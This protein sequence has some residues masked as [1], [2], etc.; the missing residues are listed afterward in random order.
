MLLAISAVWCHW[1][2]VMDQTTYSMPSVVD[3][4]NDRF[5]PI[6]VDSDRN[7]DINARYNMGGWPSTVFL[8]PNK[9][10]LTGATYVPPE[11]M[12]TLLQR[13]ADVYEAEKPDLLVRAKSNREAME[14]QFGLAHGSPTGWRDVDNVLRAVR[15]AYDPDYGGFG[16]EQKFPHTDALRLLLSNYEQRREEKDLVMVTFTLDAMIDGGVFDPVEGGMFR[17]ATQRNWSEPHYEKMLDDNAKIAAVML[18]AHR[19]TESKSYLQTA[20]KIFAYLERTLM[21][22]QTGVFFGSQ[23]ADE[24]YYEHDAE[25]REQILPPRVDTAAYVDSNCAL[26]R[27][28]LKLY[29]VARDRPAKEH[30]KRI[31]DFFNSLPRASDGSVCHY[32]E[33]GQALQHGNLSATAALILANVAVHEATGEDTYLETAIELANAS[34]AAFHS[35]SGA[36]FDISAVHA[37]DRGLSRYSTPLAEN[38]IL[39]EALIKIGDLTGEAHYRD[40]ARRIL[41]SLAGQ[42]GGYG[43]MAAEYAVALRVL[44]SHPL[45][46]TI[47]ARPGD[48]DDER[49]IQ[50]SIGACGDSCTVKTVERTTDDE[51]TTAAVCVGTACHAL[52]TD[53]DDLEDQLAEAL[54]A[55]DHE[56]QW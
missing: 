25:G 32:Y 31:V 36:Y 27:A 13:I 43:I 40:R 17:Y 8:T 46:V 14:E 24:E 35:E 9:D 42:Y 56:R 2:H 19:I 5:I 7:P 3:T 53:P 20:Q 29:A 12:V 26:A 51:P 55:Q 50:A 18:D 44:H 45:V 28:Y 4:I 41:D 54:A 37:K 34:E 22:P 1:C 15:D 52:V 39:S 16:R 38:S 21:D 47:N 6:R 49:F 10:V 33:N 23:D 48:E 30:S 11:Q